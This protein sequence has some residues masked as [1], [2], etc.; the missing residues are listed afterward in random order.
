MRFP[1]LMPFALLASAA[2]TVVAAQPAAPA[3]T[4]SAAVT[5]GRY[6]VEPVHTRLQFSL[7]HMGLTN[8]YGDLTDASGTLVLD[9]RNPAA[10]KVEVTLPVA[11][12]VTTNAKLDEELRGPQWL[13]AQAHPTIRFVSTRIVRTGARGAT[14]TGDLT[15]HGVTRPVTL[16]AVFNGAGTDPVAKAYTVGFDATA[17]IRRSDFGV[18]TYVPMIGDA[19]N[20]R[21][22][23]AFVPAPN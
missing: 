6:A 18:N 16:Q 20:I 10:A 23:A 19:V 7:S 1:Y 8:W 22:S 11:S 13:D 9:P 4:N 3:N 21:I 17:T 5:A 14:V 12:V 2:S 15:F